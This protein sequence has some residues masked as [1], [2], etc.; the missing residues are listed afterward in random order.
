M[1]FNAYS[2]RVVLIIMF[3]L[4]QIY[5]ERKKIK[6]S[7]V[8]FIFFYEWIIADPTRCI[9]FQFH[10]VA[11]KTKKKYKKKNAYTF[12]WDPSVLL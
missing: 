1:T 10:I 5:F 7:D 3:F 4:L 11:N 8:S 2:P 6:F 9:S 12:Q